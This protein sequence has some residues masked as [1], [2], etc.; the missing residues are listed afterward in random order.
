MWRQEKIINLILVI[1]FQY[2]NLECS[3]SAAWKTRH[4]LLCIPE[5]MPLYCQRA[6]STGQLHLFKV[7]GKEYLAALYIDRGC[8]YLWDIESKTSKKVFDPKLPSEQFYKVMN[9]FKINDNTI[10][11]GEE[12]TSPD[13]SRR[14]FILKMDTEELTLSSTLRLFAP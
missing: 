3:E 10:G 1:A 11:Y 13:G 12:Q 14:I 2:Q 7:S 5:R 9:I 6:K 8:L 4:Y